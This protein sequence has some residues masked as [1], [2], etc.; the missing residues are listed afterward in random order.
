M[1]QNTSLPHIGHLDSGMDITFYIF[2]YPV[3]V[4][5][6]FEALSMILLQFGCASPLHAGLDQNFRWLE[7]FLRLQKH[8]T[9]N[10]ALLRNYHDPPSMKI[11]FSSPLLEGI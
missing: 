2:Y 8:L 6:S 11:L 7:Q 1:I 4:F 5:I 3:M 9:G 10:L